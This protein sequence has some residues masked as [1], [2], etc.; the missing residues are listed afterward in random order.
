MNT[1]EM[2][3]LDMI[4]KWWKITKVDGWIEK[5]PKGFIVHPTTFK[6]A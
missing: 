2:L 3:K 5:T 6:E 4:I 1:K